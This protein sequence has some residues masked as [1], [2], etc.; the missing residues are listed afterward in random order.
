M[1][2]EFDII[3]AAGRPLRALMREFKN[4]TI[5]RELRIELVPNGSSSSAE[6]ILC[7]VEVILDS[8]NQSGN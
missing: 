2:R 5:D 4:I 8:P 3:K 1:L 6:P 7:G